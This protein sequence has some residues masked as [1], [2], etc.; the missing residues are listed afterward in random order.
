LKKTDHSD[1]AAL[2]VVVNKP[3]G[4]IRICGDYKVT[5]NSQL[6]IDQYPLPRVEDIF[7]ALQGR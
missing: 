5:I 7:A 2:V 1:L 4:G 6:E 3:D